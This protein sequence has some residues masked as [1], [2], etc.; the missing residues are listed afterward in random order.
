M[1]NFIKKHL[2]AA[3]TT[4][5]I[6][7]NPAS[8]RYNTISHDEKNISDCVVI[9]HE[10][11]EDI[12]KRVELPGKLIG[13][14]VQTGELKAVILSA[15]QVNF[16]L[17]LDIEDEY[18]LRRELIQLLKSP[19]PSA[20]RIV[21][22]TAAYLHCATRTTYAF[23]QTIKSTDTEKGQKLMV[24]I[25]QD[26]KLKNN[27]K[28]LV[29]PSQD[30][31]TVESDKQIMVERD[32]CLNLLGSNT[33]KPSQDPAIKPSQNPEPRPNTIKPSQNPETIEYLETLRVVMMQRAVGR[34]RVAELKP[35]LNEFYKQVYW[36]MLEK[37]IDTIV[38]CEPFK[39]YS[40]MYSIPDFNWLISTPRVD[41]M[42][43]RFEDAIDSEL[44]KRAK[45]DLDIPLVRRF[46]FL[47]FSF[48]GK[49]E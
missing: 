33:V 11:L 12:E 29:N 38:R 20:Q 39:A 25:E 24:K 32:I 28:L 26:M 23:F 46:F 40:C 15:E 41:Y 13:L 3:Q 31:E 49:K 14:N 8:T 34:H 22:L 17:R 30:P 1:D 43:T 27:L 2:E 44:A 19:A 42:R 4:V 48:L 10:C 7:A 47:F 9:R 16:L 21:Q 36:E 5:S 35:P 18:R 6:Y 37:D 45:Y